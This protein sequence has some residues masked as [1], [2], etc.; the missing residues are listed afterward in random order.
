GTYH[1]T[2]S[3]IPLIPRRVSST[4]H[5][6][7]Q[8]VSLRRSALILLIFLAVLSFT[9]SHARASDLPPSA[10]ALP[11]V[12]A[13]GDKIS[14]VLNEPRFLFFAAPGPGES[15]RFSGDR[16]GVSAWSDSQGGLAGG[17]RL[18]PGHWN[19]SFESGGQIALGFMLGVRCPIP[20]PAGVEHDGG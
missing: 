7:R 5:S 14:F 12:V 3:K 19:L 4:K 9:P 11:Q 1:D 20:S 15:I 18:T 6:S 16:E 17:I 13:P 2:F 10:L 8:S